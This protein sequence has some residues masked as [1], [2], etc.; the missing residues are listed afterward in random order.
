MDIL[1]P[2]L[3]KASADGTFKASEVEAYNK[4]IQEVIKK[5]ANNTSSS[6]GSS[7]TTYIEESYISQIVQN[8][9]KENY[10]YTSI[11]NVRSSATE[12]S[13]LTMQITTKK[14]N[15]KIALNY[16]IAMSHTSTKIAFILTRTVNGVTTEIGSADAASNRRNGIISVGSMDGSTVVGG[17]SLQYIDEPA[18]SKDTIIT[19]KIKI[20]GYEVGNVCINAGTDDGDYPYA[21]RVTTNLRL[22]EFDGTP[23]TTGQLYSGS[24]TAKMGYMYVR[25]EQPSGTA[26][27]SSAAGWQVRILN[28]VKTNSITNASLSTNRITLPAGKY[29]I[30][31]SCP[32]YRASNAR[33]KI[34]NYTVSSDILLGQNK[35]IYAGEAE[36]GTPDVTGEFTLSTTSEIQL[37]MYADDGFATCGLGVNSNVGTEVYAEIEI[38]EVPEILPLVPLASETGIATDSQLIEGIE[39]TKIVTPLGLRKAIYGNSFKMPDYDR[40]TEKSG[41]TVYQAPCDGYVLWIFLGSY[42]NDATVYVGSTNNPTTIVGRGFND[43]NGYTWGHSGMIPIKKGYYYKVINGYEYQS[44]FFVPCIGE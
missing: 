44:Q 7:G 15:S 41:N 25:E 11:P 21:E 19:Y 31:A 5:V 37:M 1:F 13:C 6:S 40:M 36:F 10:L 35:Y 24:N 33:C 38:W 34:Y 39:N 17:T 30:K 28:T 8:H 22:T 3:P 32:V 12:I 18:V 16:L 4:N 26:G 14:D 43:Y 29:R 20:W 9:F 42:M 2:Q 23:V 27:G